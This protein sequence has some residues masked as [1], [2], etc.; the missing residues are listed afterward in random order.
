MFNGASKKRMPQLF[1]TDIN[2]LFKN[3]IHIKSWWRQFK[4]NKSDKS[5][6]S[7]SSQTTLDWRSLSPDRPP[8]PFFL[9]EN[10]PI[11]SNTSL[12]KLIDAANRQPLPHTHNNNNTTAS[13][14]NDNTNHKHSTLSNTTLDIPIDYS[15]KKKNLKVKYAYD[16]RLCLCHVCCIH[17]YIH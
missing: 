2:K 15:N 3:K 1:A 6:N 14:S 8:L 12:H 13:N 7:S 9:S 5:S 17:M 10:S 4:V 11:S 16:T